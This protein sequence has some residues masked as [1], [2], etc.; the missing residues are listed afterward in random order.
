MHGA[1][2]ELEAAIHD[3]VDG[4]W[5]EALGERAEPYDI[6]EKHR[7][8]LPFALERALGREDL[9]GEVARG[10]GLGR[11]EF[12]GAWRSRSQRRAAA[13]AELLAGLVRELTGGAAKREQ[14]PAY[15]TEAAA[16]AVLVPAPR[17]KHQ[18]NAL[19]SAS[20]C[21]SQKRMSISRYIVVAVVRCSWACSR[22]PVRR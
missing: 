11:G 12:G 17:A 21:S 5:I 15:G 16:L 13:A 18:P 3:R 14:R 9:L 4:L 19:I 8:L 22:W 20:A 6:G 10:V 7:D 2:E 1:G